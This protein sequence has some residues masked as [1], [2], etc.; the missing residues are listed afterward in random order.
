[1]KAIFLFKEAAS[2][3]AF[4]T[5]LLLSDGTQSHSSEVQNT[6]QRCG[7]KAKSQESTDDDRIPGMEESSGIVCNRP[8]E[9]EVDSILCEGRYLNFGVLERWL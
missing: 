3:Q 6:D 4:P 8:D 7:S 9:M 5:C 2:P 1:M